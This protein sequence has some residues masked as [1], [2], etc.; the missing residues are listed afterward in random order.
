MVDTRSEFSREVEGLSSALSDLLDPLEK[1]ELEALVVAAIRQHRAHIE[2]AE[3]AEQAW[4]GAPDAEP[5]GK[6]AL[7]GIYVQAMIDHCAHMTI[8]ATLVDRLGYIPGVDGSE[9]DGPVK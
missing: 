9:E 5:N 4:R 6:R 8:L 3:V 2:S 7:Y 1:G